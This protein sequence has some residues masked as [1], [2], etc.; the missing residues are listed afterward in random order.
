MTDEQVARLRQAV[1]V[2]TIERRAMLIAWKAYRENQH[3]EAKFVA[4]ENGL[5][6]S[7]D[8]M[9]AAKVLAEQIVRDNTEE[10][11]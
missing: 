9:R 8:A 2:A 11:A 1:D 4:Y 10:P 5:Q 7:C 6:T 3:D